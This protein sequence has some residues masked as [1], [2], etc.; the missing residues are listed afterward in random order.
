[1]GLGL[2]DGINGKRLT[3]AIAAKRAQAKSEARSG[4]LT[5]NARY[6]YPDTNGH[7]LID[8][9]SSANN[10]D[11]DQSGTGTNK[12]FNEKVILSVSTGV[13]INSNFYHSGNNGSTLVFVKSNGNLNNF[14]CKGKVVSGDTIPCKFR[15]LLYSENGTNDNLFDWG[16][17]ASVEGAVISQGARKWTWNSSGT[18]P[19]PIQR[20]PAAL[21]PFAQF[22]KLGTGDCGSPPVVSGGDS[23]PPQVI[24][25]PGKESIELTPL[26]YYFH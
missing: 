17:H 1:V 14:G 26:G 15:G 23:P 2:S 22:Q 8:W 24:L 10:W 9:N 3:D 4:N 25:A 20:D 7:F 11:D 13:S 18:T 12:L 16:N 6:F 5:E 21:E 19:T